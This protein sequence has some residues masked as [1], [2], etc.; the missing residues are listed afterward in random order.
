MNKSTNHTTTI[1]WTIRSYMIRVDYIGYHT[2]GS[3]MELDDYD[4][5]RVSVVV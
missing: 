4:D 1:S 3:S 2:V 5:G